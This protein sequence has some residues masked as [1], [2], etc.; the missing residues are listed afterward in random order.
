MHSAKLVKTVPYNQDVMAGRPPIK[1]APIFGQRLAAARKVLLGGGD[2]VAQSLLL[3]GAGR[4][5]GGRGTRG[6]RPQCALV[7]GIEARG[8]AE[9]VERC[10]QPEFAP[11]VDQRHQQRA[12][13]IGLADCAGDGINRPGAG[14]SA[15]GGFCLVR[16]LFRARRLPG[17]PCRRCN[18]GRSCRPR[19]RSCRSG[20][21]SPRKRMY[22]P[23][24]HRSGSRY[25]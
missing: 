6:E 12:A 13:G 25:W 24:S 1:D 16:D 8:R 19:H 9:A 22:L 7:V 15:A 21:R 18:P 5:H 17:R 14:A 3:D 2:R 20:Y 23:G 10:E 11:A 4:R